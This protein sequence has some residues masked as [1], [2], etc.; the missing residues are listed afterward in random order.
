MLGLVDVEQCAVDL[1]LVPVLEDSGT[2]ALGLPGH[3]SSTA[4]LGITVLCM[5]ARQPV[6]VA[7]ERGFHEA[8][9]MFA[10]GN[11]D[12]ILLCG[13]IYE[14]GDTLRVV[15]PQST[16]RAAK[17]DAA[18]ECRFED[19]HLCRLFD[20]DSKQRGGTLGRGL[21]VDEDGRPSLGRRDDLMAWA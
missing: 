16:A 21:V 18:L 13:P 15:T 20:S 12:P 4:L 6:R 2:P 11:D 7:C 3:P 17:A 10:P 8:E 1:E 9:V 5:Q 19:P 14:C